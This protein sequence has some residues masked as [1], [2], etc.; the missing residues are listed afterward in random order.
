[1]FKL[2]CVYIEVLELKIVLSHY[3]LSY[4]DTLKNIYMYLF[5][6]SFKTDP[7]GSTGPTGEPVRRPIFYPIRSWKH[8]HE[9]SKNLKWMDQALVGQLCFFQCCQD[10]IGSAGRTGIRWSN[11]SDPYRFVYSFKVRPVQTGQPVEPGFGRL[12]RLDRIGI[13]F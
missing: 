9:E 8:W 11:R 6:I 12:N 1:M 2:Y 13:F 5:F 4:I 3:I 10:R 7:T